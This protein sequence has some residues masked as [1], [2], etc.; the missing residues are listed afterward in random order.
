[1]STCHSNAGAMVQRPAGSGEFST[2]RLFSGLQIALLSALTL[3]LQ[4]APPIPAEAQATDAVISGT[5]TDAQGAALPNVN[6]TA[7]NTDT[8]ST[9]TVLTGAD[10]RYRITALPT[11]KYELLAQRDGFTKT[12]VR[13]VILTVGQE[14]ERDVVLNAGGVEQTVS[15]TAQQPLV[16][17]TSN[18]VGSA[19]ISQDQVENLPIP[20][21][22][23][24]QL[25][26][27]LPATGTDTTRAQRPD[28]NVGFGSQNVAATNYL[29]DGLTN[30]I[31]GAGDPRD[32][33]QQASIQEFKVI[34]SQAPAEY[35]GR[36]G[37]VVT[38]VTKSGTNNI[39]GEAFEFFRDHYINR[40]D[41]YTDRKSVV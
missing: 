26:L 3:V 36:S 8:G 38:L 1:M 21:R 4:M 40:V 9:R 32:N 29:V 17:S 35:G 11:G 34:I 24:T 28:A 6:I 31:S 15:V 14:F 19:V 37:G 20:G 10:G 41:Y 13:D 2:H 30:M 7:R 23:A 18:E 33:I 22:Q 5:A 39:H 25:S 12:Q 27:L 16:D